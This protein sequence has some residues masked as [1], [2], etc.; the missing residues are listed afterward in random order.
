MKYVL[1]HNL[2]I[3]E[4]AGRISNTYGMDKKRLTS[5]LLARY[6][7]IS[8]FQK[9]QSKRKIF[10]KEMELKKFEA[11][12]FWE[13]KDNFPPLENDNS[14]KEEQSKAIEAL[15]K[16][17]DFMKLKMKERN[18]TI[19]YLK[20]KNQTLLKQRNSFKENLKKNRKNSRSSTRNATQPQENYIETKEN[21]TYQQ[22]FRSL[23]LLFVLNCG[24]SE[25][26]IAEVLSSI[27]SC[28]G[29]VF[30]DIPSRKSINNFITEHKIV[31]QILN[32]QKMLNSSYGILHIDCTKKAQQTYLT[33]AVTLKDGTQITLLMVPIPSENG[34]DVNDIIMNHFWDSC[35]V[36]AKFE[37]LD[38]NDV[39]REFINK[40]TAAILDNAA[41]N[42]VLVQ[43]FR[44]Y[45]ESLAVSED[46]MVKGKPFV[47]LNCGLHYNIN[48]KAKLEKSLVKFEKNFPKEPIPA[49]VNSK[50]LS[51]IY[52]ISSALTTFA[53]EKTSLIRPWRRKAC[54]ENKD[55]KFHSMIGSRDVEYFHNAFVLYTHLRNGNIRNLFLYVNIKKTNKSNIEILKLLKQC[56][57]DFKY[58]GLIRAI[59][60]FYVYIME[61]LELIRKSPSIL[62]AKSRYETVFSTLETWTSSNNLE[63]ITSINT[64]ELSDDVLGTDLRQNK[65]AMFDILHSSRP[66]PSDV[67]MQYAKLALYDFCVATKE[68]AKTYLFNLLNP[69]SELNKMSPQ[70]LQ[71]RIGSAPADNSLAER[72]FGLLGYT[73]Q[74]SSKNIRPEKAGIHVVHKQ[75]RMQ[76]HLKNEQR[77]PKFDKTKSKKIRAQSRLLQKEQTLKRKQFNDKIDEELDLIRAEN[78]E[79][80][81][82]DDSI[83]A[84]SDIEAKLLD[85]ERKSENKRDGQKNQK[86]ELC[87]Q[88]GKLR[89]KLTSNATNLDLNKVGTVEKL[90]QKLKEAV[91]FYEKEGNGIFSIDVIET[92]DFT[93]LEE[94]VLANKT[95]LEK[96]TAKKVEN[97]CKKQ[98]T[99]LTSREVEEKTKNLNPSFL[100]NKKVEHVWNIADEENCSRMSTIY[101]GRILRIEEEAKDG[102]PNWKTKYIIQYLE[103]IENTEGS[104]T[105]KYD[106]PYSTP[107]QLLWDWAEGALKTVAT[108]GNAVEKKIV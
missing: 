56:E 11:K 91:A 89:S 35:C 81:I 24:I 100:V 20:R 86:K 19:K 38:R 65:K 70:E 103:E 68:F 3:Q 85:I 51:L 23:I 80:S 34:K 50:I 67:I 45:V 47:R 16:K 44:T 2:T 48:L 54:R 74:T 69:D 102:E 59:A 94:R 63:W 61:P 14:S 58:Y 99:Q 93:L 53:K 37:N 42:N 26:K 1:D 104:V 30:S 39:F 71:E 17:I 13:N 15:Q 84:S 33:V 79:N 5:Q 90:K 106:E 8:V 29:I 62:D 105:Y 78:E 76:D 72:Q 40:F 43:N 82:E 12:I 92:P 49:T 96:E 4:I 87:E 101:R 77:D 18:Q 55:I 25:N 32:V 22:F 66:L 41:C 7:M 9:Q 28:L 52:H 31:C 60:I 88:L 36:Y 64:G 46:G 10:H 73:Q 108:F 95:T 6:R 75:N 27:T 97:L 107:L 57:E 83:W 21:N 98:N